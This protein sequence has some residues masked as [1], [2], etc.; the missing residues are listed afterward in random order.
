MPSMY[1]YKNKLIN[2]N[3]KLITKY[4]AFENWKTAS[5][6]HPAVA[7]SSATWHG[8]GAIRFQLNP[9]KCKAKRNESAPLF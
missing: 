2:K 9:S 8:K 7:W 5:E 6:S 3:N 4:K 1:A